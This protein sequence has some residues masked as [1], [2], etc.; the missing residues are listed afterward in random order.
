MW[1]F[2]AISVEKNGVL[3]GSST[4]KKRVDDYE[5]HTVFFKGTE[6]LNYVS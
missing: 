3:Q 1:V 5:T 6:S 4:E 2:T